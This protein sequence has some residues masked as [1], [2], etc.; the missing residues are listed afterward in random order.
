VEWA[1]GDLVKQKERDRQLRAKAK[2]RRREERE[3]HQACDARDKALQTQTEADTAAGRER[4]HRMW[5]K[6]QAYF[7]KKCVE[8]RTEKANKKKAERRAKKKKQAEMQRE[9]EEKEANRLSCEEQAKEVRRQV[10]SIWNHD[11]NKRMARNEQAAEEERVTKQKAV[12]RMRWLADEESRQKH[13]RMSLTCQIRAE[14]E[15]QSANEQRNK[16]DRMVRHTELALHSAMVQKH[17]KMMAMQQLDQQYVDRVANRHDNYR[18]SWSHEHRVTEMFRQQRNKQ[19]GQ[20]YIL[21]TPDQGAVDVRLTRS[22][23]T[24]G[25][26]PVPSASQMHLPSPM[27]I[28]SDG[29]NP[30]S[31]THP[32][33]T[34]ATKQ[35]H[36]L[37]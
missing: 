24:I 34:L 29:R 2:Q 22:S 4:L 10:R 14:R 23:T 9:A 6:E 36:R 18:A 37:L 35:K 7:D 32:L 26:R 3:Y 28:A 13:E 25:A 30:V 20:H 33:P 31:R 27:S 12:E 17:E 5:A 19:V 16:C 21:Q 11:H 8:L 15:Y 1:A